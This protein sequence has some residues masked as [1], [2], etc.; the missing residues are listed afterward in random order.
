M[1]LGRMTWLVLAM[2]YGTASCGTDTTTSGF[3]ADGSQSGALPGPD[4]IGTVDSSPFTGLDGKNGGGGGDP[5]QA[6]GTDVP[7]DPNTDKYGIPID[8]P[9]G[10]FGALCDD[11]SACD[12][13]FC[14]NS[15]VGKVCTDVCVENCPPS[16]ICSEVTV[17]GSDTTFI[18]KPKFLHLCDPCKKSEDCG[19]GATRSGALCLDSGQE[20]RFCGGDCAGGAPCPQ[21]FE[22]QD[23]PSPEGPPAR[24]CIPTS[25]MCECTPAAVQNKSGTVCYAE[26]GF[27]KCFGERF[28]TAD[29]L[30]TCDSKAPAIEICDGED[31]DCNGLTDDITLAQDCELTNEHGTCSGKVECAGGVKKCTGT[32]A[33]KEVCNGK[34]DNCDGKVDE[35]FPDKGKPCDGPD[36]D[37]C[38][39]GLFVC[40]T[41]GEATFCEGDT[42]ADEVCNGKDDDCNGTVDDGFPD[43]DKDGIADCVDDDEDGDGDPDATDC[44]PTDPAIYNGAPEPCDGKDNNCNGAIDEYDIDTDSDGLKDCYDDDD[45]A[46]GILDVSDNCPLTQNP[47]QVDTDDDGKGDKCDDDDDGDGIKDAFDNCPLLANTNQKDSDKDGDGDACDPDDD[48]DGVNDESD[49]CPLTQNPDQENTDG[50]AQG[51]A[52]DDNDDND[53]ELD[54]TDCMPTNP[55]VYHNAAESCDGLDN[56]CNGLVDDGLCYDGEPCTKDVCDPEKGCVYQ[57]I[58]GPCD[59][60]DGCTKGDLCSNGKCVGNPLNCDDNNPC[61]TDSC[62]VAGGCVHTNKNGS[63]CDDGNKC[64]NQDTCQNG[65]CVGSGYLSC[66]DGNPC[67]VDSCSPQTGCVYNTAQANGFSCDDNDACTTSSAC[68]GGVCTE[69]TKYKCPPQA[70]CF[71]T[72]CIDIGVPWCICL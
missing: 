41:D 6:T 48:N 71:I 51:N 25:G 18:C 69:V 68:S 37:S 47:S 23:V 61:T 14:I 42:P 63:A 72:G 26:N 24:Q 1:K 56:D 55:A 45:D 43:L 4:G 11:N 27:G 15:P 36:A 35:D 60:L 21:G 52:C 53:P 66:N 22:C 70:G 28:C 57:A 64:T 44:A 46:D 29:G 12:S 10:Q 38:A 9:P 50:D 34:D 20:G 54:V 32:E 40:T 19:D 33:S 65:S 67:T 2:V 16:W 31:N 59:D 49:N 17:T 8:A 30:S 62:N 5:D 3:G 7:E 58:A 13:A 39:A